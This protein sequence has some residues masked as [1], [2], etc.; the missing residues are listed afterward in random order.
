MESLVLIIGVIL[1]GLASSYLMSKGK[2]MKYVLAFSGA[3]LLGTVFIHLLPDL[4]EHGHETLYGYFILIGFL[5]QVAIELF[6]HGIEH[7]HV[8]NT[9]RN[10]LIAACIG[11]GVH[12]FTEGLPVEH[13]HHGEKLLSAIFVHKFPVAVVFMSFLIQMDLKKSTTWLIFIGFALLT[14]LGMW[15]GDHFSFLADHANYLLAILVGIFLHVATTI[16]FESSEGHSFRVWKFVAIVLGTG[17]AV[18]VG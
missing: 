11:L 7:G 4:F 8:H 9:H 12:A 1:G 6:T 2:F 5:L 16:I 15:V 13:V 18:L 17:L 3:Y 10:G 14:P